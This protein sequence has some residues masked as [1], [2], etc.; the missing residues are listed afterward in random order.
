MNENVL[1]SDN[2]Q[3]VFDSFPEVTYFCQNVTIPGVSMTPQEVPTPFAS[4]SVGG[5]KL[6]FDQMDVTFLVDEDLKTWLTIYDWLVSAT[7]ALDRSGYKAL[8]SANSIYSDL[9][10][11]L[12]TNNKNP[13]LRVKVKNCFPVSLSSL[14]M[15]SN[16]SSHEILTA[17]VSLKYTYFSIE[18]VDRTEDQGR[19]YTDDSISQRHH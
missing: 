10:L 9:T 4:H 12:L 13:N 5:D 11:L 14:S 17:S 16:V 18:H 1:A 8:H 6:Q 19:I 2:H 7:G 3:L 15:S